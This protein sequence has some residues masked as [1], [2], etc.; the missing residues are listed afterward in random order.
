MVLFKLGV[1]MYSKHYTVYSAYCILG[2]RGLVSLKQM[3]ISAA[4]L[5]ISSGPCEHTVLFSPADG[6]MCPAC[7]VW[8]SQNKWK[9]GTI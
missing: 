4:T 1:F 7:C 2:F 9:T 5:F 6:K 8:W 3:Y